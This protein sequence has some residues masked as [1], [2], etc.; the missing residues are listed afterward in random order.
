MSILLADQF[1][2]PLTDGTPVV[3]QAN[4]G[5]IGSSN[6]GACNSANGGCSVDFRIQNPRVAAPNTPA[7]P[8]NT[9]AGGSNDSTRPGLATIC[10][11]ST[12]GVTTIFSK[13]AIFISDR[14]L[15]PMA[16]G[17][18]VAVDS[19]FNATQVG[20]APATVGNIFPHTLAG[21]DPSGNTGSGNQGSVHVFSIG[22]T[23]PTPCVGPLP[24]TF[25]VAI[26]SPLGQATSYPFKLTFTCP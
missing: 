12:D 26:K 13:I 23:P 17:T 3:F 15:N 2:T 18:T 19:L 5:S 16:A 1:G 25:N 11:S 4:P 14:K 22:S 6:K 21:D 8:C 10:A 24:G 9:L 7:T 20:V